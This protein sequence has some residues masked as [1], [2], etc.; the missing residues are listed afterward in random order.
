[1]DEVESRTLLGIA[2]P[3]GRNSRIPA[4]PPLG[5]GHPGVLGQPL[6][7]ALCDPRLLPEPPQ[8]RTHLRS[9]EIV[10]FQ[11]IPP[12]M[13]RW[14]EAARARAGLPT[15]STEAMPPRPSDG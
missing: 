14:C 9:R 5:A 1:M 6:G 11:P 12:S 15:R 4:P 10:R 3:S 2:L 8:A 13:K 7:A